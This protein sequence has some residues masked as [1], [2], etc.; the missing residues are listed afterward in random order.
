MNGIKNITVRFFRKALS[1]QL[2]GLEDYEIISIGTVQ[3]EKN[4]LRNP[5]FLNL[6]HPTGIERTVY[7]PSL[8]EHENTI[9]PQKSAY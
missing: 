8:E 7:V 3:G 4:G 9:S 2:L 6:K 1:D 5:Y